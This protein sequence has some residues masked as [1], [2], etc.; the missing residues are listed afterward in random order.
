MDDTEPMKCPAGVGI[1]D[2]IARCELEAGHNG[3]HRGPITLG[4][5]VVIEWDDSARHPVDAPP[6]PYRGR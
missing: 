4:G 1:F 2:R 6:R 3:R 5:V